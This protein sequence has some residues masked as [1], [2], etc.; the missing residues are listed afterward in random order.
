M[1]GL[2]ALEAMFA[3]AEAEGRAAF[4]PYWPV[5][6][7]DMATS[8]DVLEAMAGAGVD[9]LEIG[10]PFSDPLA[11]GPTLQ[12]ATQQ[13]L[14]QG[15]TVKDC[16]AAVRE[17]RRR[18]V[19]RPLL[20]MGYLNP[21]LAYGIDRFVS[22]IRAAGADGL[23]VPDLPPEEAQDISDICARH[24]QALIFFLAPTSDERRIRLVAEHANGFIYCVSLTGVTGARDELPADLR[25]YIAR[26]RARTGHRLVLGFGIST[27]SQAHGMNGL[28]DGFVVASALVRAGSNEPAAA[29]ALAA[30][31]RNA[32]D[33]S[34]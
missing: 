2:P 5:G 29:V 1:R 7:P 23:L 34:P 8:L 4:L 3:A 25:D 13:A 22:D 27:P 18:K 30:S 31:L 24:G 16:V 6:Y 21:L 19:T 10:I 33:A 12:A 26:V 28:V 17:L 20:L 9:G 14:E 11:D 15:T 32:L